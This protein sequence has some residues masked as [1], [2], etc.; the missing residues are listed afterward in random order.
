MIC[1]TS[2]QMLII[3]L[4]PNTYIHHSHLKQEYTQLAQQ[5][6]SMNLHCCQSAI[7]CHNHT[8]NSKGICNASMDNM[9]LF[10][11][12]TVLSGRHEVYGWGKVL[13]WGYLQHCTKQANAVHC[14]SNFSNHPTSASNESDPWWHFTADE[15]HHRSFSSPITTNHQ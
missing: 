8:S 3:A 7:K 6:L 10:F 14:N 12:A 4:Q 15:R 1:I 9:N 2:C 13:A 11:T 5:L